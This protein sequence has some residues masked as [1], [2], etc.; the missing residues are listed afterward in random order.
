[1][2]GRSG[3]LHIDYVLVHIQ[4]MCSL[5][6]PVFQICLLRRQSLKLIKLIGPELGQ[7]LTPLPGK[8]DIKNDG[9]ALTV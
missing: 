1:M 3:I 6:H 8:Y 5:A 7:L 4:C 9:T 2:P